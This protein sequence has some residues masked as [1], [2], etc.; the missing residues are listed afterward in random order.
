MFLAFLTIGTV[1]VACIEADNRSEAAKAEAEELRRWKSVAE[2]GEEMEIPR[3][4]LKW[5]LSSFP[6][7][8]QLWLSPEE[9]TY[10]ETKTDLDDE[11]VAVLRHIIRDQPNRVNR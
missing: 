4:G 5:A 8:G 11:A 10:F 7:V 2:E 9:A 6:H 3:T 1:I